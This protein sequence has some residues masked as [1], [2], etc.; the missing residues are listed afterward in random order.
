MVAGVAAAGVTEEGPLT[1]DQFLAYV[2]SVATAWMLG[3]GVQLNRARTSLLEEQATQL[4]RE[5]AARTEAA[6]EQ[7]QARIARE[8]H[9]IVAHNVSVIVAQA[10]AAQR[11]FDTDSER[12][13]QA[14]GSIELT[15]REALTEMRRLLGVLRTDRQ[16]NRAPQPGLDQL[17]GLV[18]QMR[19]AGLPV[20][21]TIG[22]HRRP[23]AAGVELSAYRIIQ[24]ALTNVLKHAGPTRAWVDLTYHSDFLEVQVRDEGR[25]NSGDLVAGHGLVGMRQR[26]V[27][28]GGELVV[29]P[30]PTGGFVVTAQLP[31]GGEQG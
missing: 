8:L 29:G 14:L 31:M 24:E 9:D 23:L 1:D 6:V 11:V 12:S 26:V 25:G 28:V 17:P 16:E 5:Q 27:L 7:E 21:L 4:E 15:G 3:Y 20:Q 13:R 30:A 22:G 10:G 19:R 2:M 18:E